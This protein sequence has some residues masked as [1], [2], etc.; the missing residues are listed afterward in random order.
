MN[1]LM[2]RYL[3]ATAL[4][5]FGIVIS[6]QGLAVDKPW[7]GAAFILA[8]TV[9]YFIQSG[10]FKNNLMHVVKISALAFV[11]E[12]LMVAAG[13]YTPNSEMRFLVP[14]P[15]CPIWVFAL[16]VNLILRLKAYKNN[17]K[18][19]HIGPFL[20][21]FV[22]GLIVFHN[23]GADGTIVLG[24]RYSLYICSAGWG[25]IAVAAFYITNKMFP[26]KTKIA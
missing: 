9:L 22:F 18:Q 8:V 17:F 26:M 21:G 11:V 12:T 7:L 13:A 5:I 3:L 10:D 15:L 19:R 14:A 6:Y 2:F 16:W 23:L 4:F 1:K 25:I 20:V 24:Y